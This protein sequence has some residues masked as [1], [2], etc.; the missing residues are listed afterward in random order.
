ME[1]IWRM[2]SS[3]GIIPIQKGLQQ[4]RRHAPVQ[5]LVRYGIVKDRI[6]GKFSFGYAHG[7]IEGVG[8][9]DLFAAFAAFFG[10]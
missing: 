6:V 2:Y 3:H 1:N 7:P 10:G 9:Y 4:R 5:L 8:L